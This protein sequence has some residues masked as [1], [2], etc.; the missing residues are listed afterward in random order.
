M[1]NIAL[2]R[3]DSRLIHGQVCTQ[4]IMRTKARRVVIIDDEIAADP[5]L[6]QIFK[7]ATPVGL[8]LDIYST[9]DAGEKWQ[10]NQLG[11]PDP[12]LILFKNVIM[13][14]RTFLAGGK[15]PLLQVGGIGGGPGR[16]NVVSA[17]AL[18][19]EDAKMLDFMSTNGMSIYFQL[20]PDSPRVEWIEVK[21][22]YFPELMQKS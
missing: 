22:K 12:I 9:K 16:I 8:T 5:F 15:L 1:G 20:V 3:I 11:D 13:I 19:Q 2:A 4:W 10:I 17:I 14:Y 7:L 21:K 6:F 18:D